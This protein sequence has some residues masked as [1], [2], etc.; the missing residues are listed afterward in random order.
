MGAEIRSGANIGTDK[1]LSVE[2]KSLLFSFQQ[3]D[4]KVENHG[5]DRE[6]EATDG[7]D[8]EGKPEDFAGA[9]EEEGNEA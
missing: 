2:K 4:W 1:N 5:N 7:A 9:I 3:E 6:D 8:G